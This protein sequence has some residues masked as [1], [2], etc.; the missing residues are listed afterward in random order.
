MGSNT[1]SPGITIRGRAGP[2]GVDAVSSDVPQQNAMGGLLSRRANA[3][4]DQLL[5]DVKHTN[6][7]AP[8]FSHPESGAQL[9]FRACSTI[10]IVP[11]RRVLWRLA[12]SV[13]V[14]VTVINERDA[15]LEQRWL[16]LAEFYTLFTFM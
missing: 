10:G 12:N 14:V 8:K 15:H 5:Q 11:L 13:F 1:E 4:Y 6:D 7:I 2:V 16:T 9:S 3:T